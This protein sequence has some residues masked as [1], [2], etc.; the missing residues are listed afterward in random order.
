MLVPTL[1]D[2]NIR[3][4]A[5]PD[6]KYRIFIYMVLLGG[7]LSLPEILRK[8]SRINLDFLSIVLWLWI[9]YLILRAFFDPFPGFATEAA[10]RNSVWAMLAL[11]IA[12]T[13]TTTRQFLILIVLAVLGQLGPII[14]A[15]GNTFDQFIY[16]QWILGK[17]WRWHSDLIGEERGMIWSSLA[18]PNY[19]ASYASL[20]LVWLVLV[21]FQVKRKWLMVLCMLYML[22]VLYTLL[23][24]QTRG[25]W[26]GLIP[27]ALFIA[28]LVGLY[29]ANKY[30]SLLRWLNRVKTPIAIFC[31]VFII[32]IAGV[33]T[34]ESKDGPM[35]SVMKRYQHAFELRDASLRARPLMWNACIQMWSKAP[36][37]GQGIDR[38][39][40][41]FLH[42]VH[43]I[44]QEAGTLL[45]QNITK[46][47]NTIRS[48]RAHNDYLQY[49]AELGI[50]GFALF[51]L[52]LIHSIV[53]IILTIF[54]YQQCR[55]ERHISAASL[56]TIVL[57]GIFCLF[58]FPLRLP[59]SA[60]FFGLGLAGILHTSS[61]SIVF[62]LP[63]WFRWVF[64]CLILL[65]YGMGTYL[66]TNHFTASHLQNDAQYEL[67][68]MNKLD[69]GN[70]AA[71]YKHLLN[72]KR[73]LEAASSRYPGS[74]EILYDLG[75]VYAHLYQYE[76]DRE[77]V[78][79]ST[80]LLERSKETY[81]VPETYRF[82]ARNY[83][84]LHQSNPA[85]AMVEKLRVV[86]P[87][88]DGIENL[89]GIVDYVAANYEQAEQHFKQQLH[90]NESNDELPNEESMRYLGRIYEDQQR[91]EAAA[92]MYENVLELNPGLYNIIQR[93]AELYAT[94]LNKLLA[95][96]EYYQKALQIA[97]RYNLKNDIR[98][99][100]VRLQDIQRRLNRKL[101]AG[102]E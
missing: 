23:Y 44:A 82:L 8:R 80:N 46:Q 69:A 35:H 19:Y 62:T 24:T 17:D 93:L 95:A 102:N 26:A 49:L 78:H 36:L 88:R 84:T 22:A 29:H 16:L 55:L 47:M 31:I 73:Y 85:R 65:S 86:D 2:L 38:Y 40:P 15:I 66:I 9:L 57:A 43:E 7:L 5:G 32:L 37:F 99:I 4:S 97:E 76:N 70:S 81:C 52:L 28:S 42:E 68:Q 50:I 71:R 101:D 30:S 51:L 13:C 53:K 98:R 45:V 87:T 64:A 54:S 18:N 100:T 1:V 60:L 61:H 39:A 6:S 56:A 83:L 3:V 92:Q 21:Y 58:D 75:R 27:T 89:A 96:K 48:D 72:A 94:E 11:F 59:A 25:V 63:S 34:I 90:I 77:Y 41:N 91:F 12:Y 14:L 10:L 20:F 74:G 67:E 79:R 33:Y